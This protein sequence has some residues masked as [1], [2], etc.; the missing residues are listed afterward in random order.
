MR[1]YTKQH[2][3]YCGIDLHARATYVCTLS[4]DGEIV[5]HRG[6]PSSPDSFLKAI[7]PSRQDIVVA[8]QCIFTWS[9]DLLPCRHPSCPNGRR[10]LESLDRCLVQGLLAEPLRFRN[11]ARAELPPGAMSISRRRFFRYLP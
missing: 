9:A 7:A 1:F 2:R 3:S 4:Q 10:W 5:F 6:M 11:K 8:V